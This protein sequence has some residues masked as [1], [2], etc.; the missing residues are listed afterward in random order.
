MKRYIVTIFVALVGTLIGADFNRDGKADLLLVKHSTRQTAIWHMNNHNLISQV[1]GPTVPAGWTIVGIG[2]FNGNGYP[3]VLIY[4][5]SSHQTVIWHMHDGNLINSVAGPTFINGYVP[6]AVAT[7]VH[8]TVS[9]MAFNPNTRHLYAVNM[10]DNIVVSQFRAPNVPWGWQLV[11]ANG[12][13][14]LHYPDVPLVNHD[15][16]QIHLVNPATR[17]TRIWNVDYDPNSH[18]VTYINGVTGVA[19]PAGWRLGSLLDAN[20][21][22]Y[23]DYLLFS[24]SDGRTSFWYLQDSVFLSGI[25]G[26]R[27]PTGWAPS[28]IGF[29]V[30]AFG[31]RPTTINAPATYSTHTITVDTGWD[32]VWTAT[33]PESWI[34]ITSIVP[35]RG[36]NSIYIAVAALPADAPETTARTGT[37]TVA[38]HTVTVHQ[39]AAGVSGEWRGTIT[40]VLHAGCNSNCSDNRT[41]N[42]DVH[43]ATNGTTI[44]GPATWDGLPCWDC[45]SCALLELDNSSGSITGTV[46]TSTAQFTYSGTYSGSACDGNSIDFTVTAVITNGTTMTGTTSFG[47]QMILNKV[48]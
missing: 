1:P 37:V 20:L 40:G 28:L 48:Q 19:I 43:I 16:A 23:L 15:G 30:C 29:P 3:D 38:G 34:T 32:C 4:K 12:P 41:S 27:I 10:N 35:K 18:S 2:D 14:S 45:N 33:S 42:F 13:P 47:Q 24:P 25:Y 44:S 39:D 31:V 17:Q 11:S 9:I 36:P 8:N 26:P 6:I 22:S 7:F 46:G 5:T 21:D